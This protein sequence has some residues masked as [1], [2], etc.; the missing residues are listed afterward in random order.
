MSAKQNAQLQKLL[1]W[2]LEQAAE[3]REAE[4]AAEREF[5]LWAVTTLSIERQTR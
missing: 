5:H 3:C 2:H 4:Q 1:D